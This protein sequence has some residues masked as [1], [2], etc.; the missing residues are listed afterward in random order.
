MA[1]VVST[2]TGSLVTN[3]KASIISQIEETQLAAT[4]QSYNGIATFT[5]ALEQITITLTPGFA[6]ISAYNITLGV[7]GDV[8]AKYI[9]LS[10]T[11]F[12]LVPTAGFDGE[13]SWTADPLL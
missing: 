9:K 8:G 4:P 7:S 3:I 11:S 13:V 2:T 6:G 1:T 10:G 12:Q 5:E